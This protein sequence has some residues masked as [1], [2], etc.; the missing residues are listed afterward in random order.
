MM[1]VESA[2]A[3]SFAAKAQALP[4]PVTVDLLRGKQ[5]LVNSTGVTRFQLTALAATQLE[6]IVER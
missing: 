4:L 6:H 1:T 2:A 5:Q 3:L